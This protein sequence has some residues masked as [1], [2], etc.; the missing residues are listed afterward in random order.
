[1][2][3]ELFANLLAILQDNL[4]LLVLA[5][6]FFLKSALLVLLVLYFERVT[7][8][9]F[10]NTQKYWLWLIVLVMLGTLP[11]TIWLFSTLIEQLPLDREFTLFTLLVPSEQAARAIDGGESSGGFFQL[12]VLVYLLVLILH[13][14]K[15]LASFLQVNGLCRSA[16]FNANASTHELLCH[17][18]RRAGIR[19]KVT[20]GYSN[21]IS[22]PL[23]F[24]TMNPTILLP[25]RLRSIDKDL[26][27]SILIHELSHIKHC[28]HLCYVAAYLLAAMNWFNPFIWGALRRLSLESEH[29]CDSEVVSC[30]GS[31][32]EFARQLVELARQGLQ[33]MNPRIATRSMYSRGQLFLRVENILHANYRSSTGRT[34]SSLLPIF[35]IF[36]VFCLASS[37]NIL[38]LGNEDQFST[39]ALRLV[40]SE[41]PLYP[42]EAIE[43]GVT[44]FARFSFTVDAQGLVDPKS[45]QL[46]DS[47]PRVVF[48][49]GSIAALEKYQ[50]SPR[51]IRG[52]NVATSGQLYTFEYKIRI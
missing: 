25:E 4:Y 38:A 27:E 19:R 11:I 46:V 36:A 29:I 34:H 3:I 51:R 13:L 26:L 7:A 8:P 17:L 49:E 22:S 5:A 31:R 45:I 32:T 6:D 35:I 10:S 37:G 50:F 14:S 9:Y 24:G 20:L 15:L 52:R 30:K 44:G 39:Q 28:D 21:K 2:I 18:A 48:D 12:G 43:R 47:E 41:M 40:Q 1:M 33:G 23:T 42:E 16:S